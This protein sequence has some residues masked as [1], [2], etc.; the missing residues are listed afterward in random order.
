ME[1]IFEEEGGSA[2]KQAAFDTIRNCRGLRVRS[3]S[4]GNRSKYTRWQGLAAAVYSYEVYIVTAAWTDL[5]INELQ[6]V[7]FSEY[8]DQADSGAM[9][10]NELISVGGYD[11]PDPDDERPTVEH[12]E[13]HTHGCNRYVAN[14]SA[15]CCPHCEA[16]E[17]A[18]EDQLLHSQGCDVYHGELFRRGEWDSEE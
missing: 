6:N 1:T 17:E 15:Y 9:T 4:T 12:E 18:G 5:L 8:K 13:C 2:G 10:Y 7:P 11:L 16:C 3:V 14:E